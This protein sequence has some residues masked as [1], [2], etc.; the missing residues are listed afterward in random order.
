MTERIIGT[1]ALIT[2]IG[3]LIAAYHAYMRQM[4]RKLAQ[5]WA[6][7]MFRDYAENCEYR[8]HM[9]VRATVHVEEGST[10][11]RNRLPDTVQ[12]HTNSA[13]GFLS[14]SRYRAVGQD[15]ER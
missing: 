7:E 15:F 14:A 4:Y 10:Y 2:V 8:V 12:A 1:I 13:S 3:G 5:E 9:T 6:D 11:A